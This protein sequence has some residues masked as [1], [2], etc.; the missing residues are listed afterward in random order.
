MDIMDVCIFYCINQGNIGQGKGYSGKR[1]ES[2]YGPNQTP[3]IVQYQAF[4]PIHTESDLG[5]IHGIPWT[6]QHNL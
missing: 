6:M 4:R 1:C 2:Q 3:A 5:Y